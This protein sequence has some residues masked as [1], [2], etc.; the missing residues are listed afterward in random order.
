MCGCSEAT[1]TRVSIALERRSVDFVPNEIEETLPIPGDHEQEKSQER[2]LPLETQG[3][4]KRFR[5][6]PAKASP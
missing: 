5:A 3:P 1:N 2:I 4:K 6:Y